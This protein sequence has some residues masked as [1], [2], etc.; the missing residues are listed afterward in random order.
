MPARTKF[1][2]E[3]MPFNFGGPDDYLKLI[4]G[5]DRKAFAVHLNACNVMNCPDRMHHNGAVIRERFCKLGPWI[6]SCHAKDLNWENYPQV[7]L[8]EVIP[9]RGKIDYKAAIPVAVAI[10]S[11]KAGVSGDVGDVKQFLK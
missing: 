9:G 3:M 11:Q 5:V 10:F 4:K 7:C 8:R 2:M 1:T 6:A